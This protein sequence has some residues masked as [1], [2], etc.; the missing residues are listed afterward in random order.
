[1]KSRH[2]LRWILAALVFGIAVLPYLVYLTGV[3]T[4]GPYGPGGVE[5]FYGMFLRDLAQLRPA[6]LTLALGPAAMVLAWRLV[7]AYAWA[8]DT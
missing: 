3:R 2:T 5:A 1:M 8:G 7:T 4:L 6:A